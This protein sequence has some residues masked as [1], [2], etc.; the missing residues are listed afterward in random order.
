[1]K[2]IVNLTLKL[3]IICAL[4]AAA[5][6]LTYYVTKDPIAEGAK[7]RAE[8]ARKAVLSEADS[9]EAV[10]VDALKT[11]GTWTDETDLSVTVD[12]AYVAYTSDAKNGMTVQ[13]TTKGYNPGIV[14]TVGFKA[15]GTVEAINIGS[16]SETP[17]LGANATKPEFTGQ[18][19]DQMP[20]FSLNGADG[21]SKIDALTS[22][23]FT[24]KGVVNGVNVAYD[25]FEAVYDKE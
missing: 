13:V 23:T 21:T 9:F 24:S 14:L 22:A 5:L 17:G 1:M 6:G 16:M 2:D 8:E 10:D 4:A 25:F 3:F 12:E 7:A 19:A 11:D 18:F 15:D 20:L